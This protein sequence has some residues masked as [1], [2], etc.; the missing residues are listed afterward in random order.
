M[1][2]INVFNR[3]V[4]FYKS[5]SIMCSIIKKTTLI[6]VLIFISF[7]IM[8]QSKIDSLKNQ[9]MHSTINNK[10]DIYNQISSLYIDI[11]PDSAIKYAN[12]GVSLGDA[13]HISYLKNDLLYNLGLSYKK[14]NKHKIALK[15]LQLSYDG[16]EN[17]KN[18]LK[19]IYVNNSIGVEYGQTCYYDKALSCFQKSL[20]LS[21]ELKDTMRISGSLT[22]IGL[23]CQLTK[24]YKLALSNFERALEL[25]KKQNRQLGI[26][27][28]L[29]DISNTYNLMGDNKMALK[30]HLNALSIYKKLNDIRSIAFVTADIGETYKKLKDIDL[31]LKYYLEAF[32]I[33]KNV[34]DK[35][36]SSDL[37]FNVGDLYIIKKNY[38][39]AKEFL[40]NARIL[41]NEIENKQT[42]KDVY[43]SFS[44]FYANQNE[45]QKALEFHKLFKEMN[46]SIYTKENKDKIAEL[47]IKFD[48]QEKENENEILRQ[49]TEIQQLAIHKQIYLRNTFIYISVIITLL[50]I[51][52]I[53]RYWLKQRAN[54]ILTE[55][56]D[57]INIQKNELEEVYKTKDKLFSIITHD[58]KNPFGSLVSLCSFIESNYYTMDDTHKYKGVES[59]K[60]SIVEIYNLLENLTD[61]LNSKGDNINLDKNNFDLSATIS[62]VMKLYITPAEQKSIN[63]QNHVDDNIIVYGDERMVKTILRNLIDNAIKF[64]PVKGNININIKDGSKKITVSVS[65]NGIGIKGINKHKLFNIETHFSTKG[66]DYEG[67][68]GLGLI[69]TKEFVEKNDGEIWFESE[70][71]KGSTFYFT[72]TKG[73]YYEKN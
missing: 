49:K 16:F 60:R 48:I 12:M 15:Y 2:N 53:F 42:L 70:T 32:S 19:Q 55:K 46:D 6:V 62:S 11:L 9:L 13:N 10:I 27:H 50:I 38:K 51:F 73:I 66:T 57:L 28:A 43:E 63:L 41:S 45:F 3:F 59:L 7:Y 5:N 40:D 30:Y 39:K 23:I 69:L 26:A 67:G 68:G 31:A 44:K 20:V 14:L 34:D 33:S 22:N 17:E 64:T 1:N 29:N 4:K 65:D 18:K 61:W 72:L 58:L 8:A 52:I 36:L 71:G 25:S 54:K 56:N 24:D 47:Q 35:F 21:N 37:L